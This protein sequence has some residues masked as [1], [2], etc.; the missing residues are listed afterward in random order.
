MV[1]FWS[2]DMVDDKYSTICFVTPWTYLSYEDSLKSKLCGTPNEDGEWEDI[3]A[4]T[5]PYAA[6]W[7]IGWETLNPTLDFDRIDMSKVILVG[8]EPPWILSLGGGKQYDNWE[9]FPDIKYKCALGNSHLFSSWTSR[10][11]YRQMKEFS[12]QPKRKKLCVVMSDKSFCDG[13]ASRLDFIRRFCQKYP[14]ILDI[15][16]KGM[17]NWCQRH[18]LQSH[19][20]GCTE[21]GKDN[22]KHDWSSRYQYSLAFENGVLN[23]YFSEKIN[24][25]MMAF[26]KPIFWGAQDIGRYFPKDSFNYL[27]IKSPE[28]PDVLYNMIQK[29]ITQK[30]VDAMAEARRLIMDV[31]SEWPCIKRIIDTGKLYPEWWGK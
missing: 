9:D 17:G 6:D 27:D 28:A 22:S 7:V 23:G 13:Q 31:W 2:L 20:R 10:I 29:P 18:G 19:Y 5:D 14:G 30:D 8:R 26:S 21:F 4:I 3:K 12:W 16:G 11:T 1:D 24:D 15:Y 25:P